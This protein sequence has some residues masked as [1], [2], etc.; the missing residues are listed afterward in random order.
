M[1]KTEKVW[2]L[3]TTGEASVQ[4]GEPSLNGKADLGNGSVAKCS[5]PSSTYAWAVNAKPEKLGRSLAP[6]PR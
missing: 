6:G 3:L 2:E 5:L 1:W 4:L